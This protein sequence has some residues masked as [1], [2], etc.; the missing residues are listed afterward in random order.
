MT[1]PIKKRVTRKRPTT[2]QAPAEVE[3]NLRAQGIRTRNAIIHA[4]KK[5]LIEGGSLEFTL[6]EVAL[7]AEISVSNLQYYFPTRLAVLRAVLEPTINSLLDELKRALET[8]IA[9][10]ESLDALAKRALR[11]SKDG[12]KSALWWH[13]IS[14]AAIDSECSRLFDEW[15]ETVTRAIAYVIRAARPDCGEADSL[16]RAALLMAMADGLS[17]Q[18]G[19]GRRNRAYTRGIEAKFLSVVDCVLYGEALGARKI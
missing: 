6:R 8:G 3:R 10:S 16:Q 2:T 11:D 15:Y 17:F 13:F 18:T 4:A 12:E 1:E 9:P 14:L 19:A 7:R 5:L